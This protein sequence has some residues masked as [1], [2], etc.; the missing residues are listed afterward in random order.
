[1][2]Y[3]WGKDH[4]AFCKGLEIFTEHNLKTVPNSF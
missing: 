3:R 2:E 1:M 4:W